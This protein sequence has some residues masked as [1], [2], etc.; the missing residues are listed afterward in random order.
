VY[1]LQ[2][3]VWAEGEGVVQTRAGLEVRLCVLLQNASKRNIA[4]IGDHVVVGKE[5]GSFCPETQT[6]QLPNQVQTG[7]VSAEV[8]VVDLDVHVRQS[9][10]CDSRFRRCG[11]ILTSV[12]VAQSQIPAEQEN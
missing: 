5:Q 7:D 2:V 11:K 9:G 12:D 3:H 1:V 6:E 8:N 10:I 4:G